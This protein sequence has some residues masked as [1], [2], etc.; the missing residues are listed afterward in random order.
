MPKKPPRARRAEQAIGLTGV[1]RLEGDVCVA[2]SRE[3]P[4]LPRH[5]V[6]PLERILKELAEDRQDR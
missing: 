5:P 4:P 1:E 2:A 3:G 6:A